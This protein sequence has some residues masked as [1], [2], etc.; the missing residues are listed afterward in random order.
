MHDDDIHLRMTMKT[1][2]RTMTWTISCSSSSL[3]FTPSLGNRDTIRA[4]HATTL[5]RQRV[6]S[7]QI[8]WLLHYYYS[9]F[10]VATP[11]RHWDLTIFEFFLVPEA[12]LRCC[13]VVVACPALFITPRWT[14]QICL[15]L[16]QSFSQYC[17]R[18]TACVQGREDTGKGW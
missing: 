7:P 6:L 13:V 8:C 17:S 16:A 3:K 18:A 10:V 12:V 11:F 15:S 4:G 5:P 2:T 14:K 9:I 1:M